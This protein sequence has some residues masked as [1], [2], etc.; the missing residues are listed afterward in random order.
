MSRL[1]VSSVS[2]RSDFEAAT[3]IMTKAGTETPA[4]ADVAFTEIIRH[5]E[6]KKTILR[7]LLSGQPAVFRLYH[8]A[9]E[10]CQRHWA[11]LKRIWPFLQS[12]EA[13]VCQPLACAPKAGV[14]AV[15]DV[16][17]TPLLQHFYQSE[18]ETRAR[19]LGP[20]ARWLRAYTDCSE[21]D[22]EAGAEGWT[23]R[24]ERAAGT[25][26]FARLRNLEKP[27]VAEMQRLAAM[28]E[29][30]RW[31]I[32]I[33]HGDFHPNNLIAGP[34]P[35]LTGIDCGGSRRMPIYKDM[36]RFLMHM[37]RR[38]MIPSGDRY[39]GV[40]R[41]GID[42]FAEVFDLTEKERRLYLPFFIAVEALLRVETRDLSK[43]RIRHACEMTEA[44]LSD[45]SQIGR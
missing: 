41:T 22:Y 43:A 15:S 21:T 31:R 16:P 3:T 32:A 11:E 8:G 4:L 17:G 37:G 25:Q 26:A 12:G 36:A 45:I 14:L 20:A 18:P 1:S 5:I 39:L 40:D 27:L 38:G 28:I 6:G 10:E 19:W 33:G 42:A 13:T 29:G 9:E 30:Q 24:A 34:Y 2:D 44:L 23:T 35:E 7:G